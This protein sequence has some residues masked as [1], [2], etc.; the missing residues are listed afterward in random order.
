MVIGWLTNTT[1]EPGMQRVDSPSIV[2]YGTVPGV[3][4]DSATGTS[5]TYTYGPYTSGQI[6]HVQ[7]RG[8]APR[9]VYY[10]LVAGP[11]SGPPAGEASFTS[12]AGPASRRGS[13]PYAFA[14]IGDVGISSSGRPLDFIVG[15]QDG[16]T[17]KFPS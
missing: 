17:I 13:F 16:P 2:K 8:L 4:T 12:N 15:P 1:A 14:L 11:A 6:H 10:Y 9:T 5:A 7:L 3:Y